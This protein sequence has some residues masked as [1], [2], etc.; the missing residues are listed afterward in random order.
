MAM[1]MIT[2]PD[3]GPLFSG[4]NSGDDL[5]SGTL[6]V[7]R[8]LSDLPFVKEHRSVVH[9]I[10][11]TGGEVEKRIAIAKDDP[12]FLMA[13]IEI[14]ATYKL[15]NINRSK[16]ENI[17]H[18]FFSASKLHIE[19]RDRFGKLVKVREWF[20]VPLFI[21]D[22]MVEKIKDGTVSNYYYDPASVELKQR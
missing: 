19:I 11:V 20:L 13:D 22:E 6:Y 7:L 15:A 1:T 5:N 2:D 18:R 3:S 10:G 9:K 12:T 8:S 4:V 17:I 14:I 21:I 16:L